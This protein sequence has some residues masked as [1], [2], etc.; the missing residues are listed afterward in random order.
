MTLSLCLSLFFFPTRL[1]N[2]KEGAK[3]QNS[4]VTVRKHGAS[5]TSCHTAIQSTNEHTETSFHQRILQ[6]T[7][8]FNSV[9]SDKSSFMLCS[10][11]SNYV[12]KSPEIKYIISSETSKVHTP[13]F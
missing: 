8:N 5:N 2:A 4:K 7:V 3:E 10:V 1:I 9:S 12:P 11:C 6:I 13:Y